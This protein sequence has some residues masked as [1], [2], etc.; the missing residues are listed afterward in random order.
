MIEDV[1]AI[2]GDNRLASIATVDPDGWPHCTMIG[3]ANVRTQ[4]YFAI[5][6]TSQKWLDIQRDSRVS[7]AIGRDVIDPSSI[8]ALAIKARAREVA[9][10]HERRNA[11][12][13]LLERR[14]ALKRLE[15]PSEAQS[16]II[17]ATPEEIRLLDYSGE[18]GHSFLLKV[19]PTGD[20]IST[21]EQSHDWGFGASLKPT[22]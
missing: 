17:S 15:E 5:A 12:Q 13:L 4:L 9:D 18:Y 20:V 8:R 11:I 6:R 16:V 22:S 7:L 10:E 3:F 2:L 1:I 19:D 21:E 14:P